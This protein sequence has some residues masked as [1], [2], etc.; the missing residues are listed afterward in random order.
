MV[1]AIA[2]QSIIF[3]CQMQ[4][5]IIVSNYEFY[6]AAGLVNH[7]FKIGCDEDMQPAKLHEYI[8]DKIE[9]LTPQNDKE[10]YLLHIISIYEYLDDYDEQMKELFRWGNEEEDL[11]EV[12][13]SRES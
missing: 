11:W 6:Y 2:R 5:S 8:L 1:T 7:C 10:K 4:K 13:T 3:K 9:G 12:K